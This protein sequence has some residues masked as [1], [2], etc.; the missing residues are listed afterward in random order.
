M[1]TF[2]SD[3]I[4]AA[5]L[6]RGIHLYYQAMGF[7]KSTKSGPTD[8]VTQ[9]DREAESAIRAYLLARHPDHAVFG[10]EEGQGSGGSHRW[11]VDPL[12]GTV[13]YAHGFPF[14]AVSIA[15]EVEG[16]MTHGVVLD[17]ARNELFTAIRGQGA[18][19]NSRP[20]H[21]SP[22]NR[23][24][25]S[26]LA[27]GFP[28]DVDR[29][30]ENLGYF[31]RILAKGLTVRRPGA[32]ALDLCYV[33]AGRM[34]GFWEIK[35]NPWDIAAGRLI[36][37]EAGGRVSGLNGEPH[38]LNNRYIVATNGHIHQALLSTLHGKP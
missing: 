3:A 6:A 24:I 7:T 14:F 27:T 37:E 33:A 13:N 32:A 23:L 15:L 9:A 26:L 16:R 28:Y 31:E 30:R 2:L 5:Y 19:L 38:Q 17:T 25:E 21:V 1:D 10:E 34:E 4:N 18:L 22:T 20:I 35:L 29:D 11:I 36:V 12:D 8:L